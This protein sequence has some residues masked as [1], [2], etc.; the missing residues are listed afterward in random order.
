MKIGLSNRK[1]KMGKREKEKEIIYE[2]KKI[3]G[4]NEENL[5]MKK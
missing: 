5:V 1:R 4:N 3:M 2:I